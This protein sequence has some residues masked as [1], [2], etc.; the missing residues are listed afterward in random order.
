[1]IP[2]GKTLEI[3]FTH[4]I[5]NSVVFFGCLVSSGMYIDIS[6]QTS[7]DFTK[8]ALNN[9]V[10]FSLV[11]CH[12]DIH[13]EIQSQMVHTFRKITLSLVIVIT[14]IVCMMAFTVCSTSEHSIVSAA[15]V[16]GFN[17]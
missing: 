10:F 11:V 8:H 14:T 13:I 15:I 9:V 4:N 3:L 7:Q 1:M 17:E 6:R 12:S 2:L 5:L 16:N